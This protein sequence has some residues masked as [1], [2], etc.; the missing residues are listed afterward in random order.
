MLKEVFEPLGLKQTHVYERFAKATGNLAQGYRR[1]FFLTQ[2][3]DAPTYEGNKPAGYIISSVK[4]MAIWMKIQMGTIDGITDEYNKVVKKSHIA[5]K[6]FD[7]GSDRKY[8]AGWEV[9]DDLTIVTHSG[10]NPNFATNVLMFPEEEIGI[11]ML[12]NS[13]NTNVEINEA[14]KAILDG[15]TNQHYK[16]SFVQTFDS[17]LSIITIVLTALSLVIFIW[18][19]NRVRNNGFDI[20]TNKPIVKVLALLM[21]ITSGIMGFYLPR[22]FNGSWE[23]LLIWQSYSILT[24]MIA[25]F[26]LSASFVWLVFSKA[27]PKIVS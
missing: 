14:I 1:S 6:T 10:G 2:A 9:N 4:D 15:D 17:V 8:A 3:Y 12:S 7:V 21:L 11:C 24:A 22:L 26:L 20:I 23:F 27:P 18:G 5:N 13:A 16:V 25:L 19:T